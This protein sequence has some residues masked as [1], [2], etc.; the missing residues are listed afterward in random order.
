MA[1]ILEK[2]TTTKEFLSGWKYLAT[3]FEFGHDY[4]VAAGEILFFSHHAQSLPDALSRW[5]F[6]GAQQKKF[7]SRNATLCHI[8]CVRPAE[9]Y[10]S[11]LRLKVGAGGSWRVIALIAVTKFYRFAVEAGRDEFYLQQ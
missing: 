4:R 6:D 3:R 10:W 1:Q 11:F 8:R 5:A 7:P 9:I 2:R